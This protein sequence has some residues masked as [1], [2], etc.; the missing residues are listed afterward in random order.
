L[1][2]RANMAMEVFAECG[3]DLLMAGHLHT[4]H[5]ANTA[6]R[7]KIS[8]YAALVVQAGTATSTRG[9]GEVNSFNVIR[10]EQ[11]RIEVDRYGW[12]TVHS[13]FQ[14]LNT[15]KFLRSGN[16]WNEVADGMYAAGI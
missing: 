8:E 6:A 7:Y 16:I 14:L 3:V 1:I 15:E 9:R 4:S 5:A 12:D 2:D 13:Q 10:I 11:D